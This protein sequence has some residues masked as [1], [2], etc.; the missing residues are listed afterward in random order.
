MLDIIK[1]LILPSGLVI[2]CFMAGVILVFVRKHKRCAKFMFGAAGILYIF[3]GYG[4]VSFWLLGN[5]E[6]QYPP[7]RSIEGLRNVDTIVVL[8][9]YA[10]RDKL[11]PLTS[12]VNSATAFRTLEAIRLLRVIPEA[13]ILIPGGGDVPKITKDLFVALGTPLEKVSIEDKSGN[14]YE[15]A[16]NVKKRVGDRP[17]ILVTSAGHMPRAM[18]V[19]HKLGMKPTPAPT[20]Y[21]SAGDYSATTYLPSPIYLSYSDFA[22]HEYI[23]ILWY[24][25]RNWM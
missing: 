15:N 22:I 5:L 2:I 21:M 14:T 19:F 12:E 13:G 4:P 24:R 25:L 18:G 20:H 6:Y 7:L 10:K 11:R 3:F 1:D 16:I 23:G 17:F 8:S 9:G